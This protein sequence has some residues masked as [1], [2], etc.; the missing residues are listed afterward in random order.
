MHI[1][2]AMKR[3]ISN[4]HPPPVTARPTLRSSPERVV[5]MPVIRASLFR[6]LDMPRALFHEKEKPYFRVPTTSPLE[7]RIQHMLGSAE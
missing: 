6:A 5:G 2:N 4:K 1:G 7:H 3:R